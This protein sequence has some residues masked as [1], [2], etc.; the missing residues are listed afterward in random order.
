MYRR[1]EIEAVANGFVASVGCQRL[2]YTGETREIAARR[3]CADLEAYLIDPDKTEAEALKAKCFNVR[4]TM[5][6]PVPGECCGAPGMPPM[7][8]QVQ[9]MEDTRL[10]SADQ[11]CLRVR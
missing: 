10:G 2:V 3:L 7:T 5:L 6:G 8:G 9:C 4:H 11:D 1:L